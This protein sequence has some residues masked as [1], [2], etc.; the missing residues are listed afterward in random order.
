MKTSSKK[1][2]NNKIFNFI[3]KFYYNNENILLILLD[4]YLIILIFIMFLYFLYFLFNKKK[5]I[6]NLN[7][8]KIKKGVGKVD[9]SSKKGGDSS[10]NFISMVG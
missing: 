1:I 9:K 8:D 5:F 10:D 6:E 3:R 4:N 2:N 7:V